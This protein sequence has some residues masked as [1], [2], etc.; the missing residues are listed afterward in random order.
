ML[1]QKRHQSPN[2]RQHPWVPKGVVW[3]KSGGGFVVGGDDQVRIKEEG[4][5]CCEVG[6]GCDVLQ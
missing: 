1:G 5:W 4:L 6:E 3:Q 2:Q